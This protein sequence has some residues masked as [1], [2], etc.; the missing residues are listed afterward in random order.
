MDDSANGALFWVA[1]Y[2]NAV[3]TSLPALV[4]CHIVNLRRRGS[5]D[6]GQRR[7]CL[8]IIGFLNVLEVVVTVGMMVR[9]QGDANTASVLRMP[10]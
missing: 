9:R 7:R 6:S 2:P 4:A 5:P 10:G 3:A 1:V 8:R